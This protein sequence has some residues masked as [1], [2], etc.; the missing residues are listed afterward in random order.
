MEIPEQDNAINKLS[1]LFGHRGNFDIVCANILYQIPKKNYKLKL[2]N[3]TI[4]WLK[5]QYDQTVDALN[6]NIHNA[7][8][9]YFIIL[10]N[11]NIQEN[12]RVI[13]TLTKIA[14]A[15]KLVISAATKNEL[16]QVLTS[17]WPTCTIDSGNVLKTTL[18]RIESHKS[19]LKCF[20]NDGTF[21]YMA[22]RS[23]IAPSL[24][25]QG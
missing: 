3:S 13:K 25:N 16:E 4:H 11:E 19:F 10:N 12:E 17:V 23:I 8:R 18:K 20:Y 15:A 6:E 21:E 14:Q 24:V 2:D 9:T 22:F 5:S 1:E 7:Q